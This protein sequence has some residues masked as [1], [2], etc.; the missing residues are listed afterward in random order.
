[1]NFCV[2]EVSQSVEQEN[3]RVGSPESA[4]IHFNTIDVL[5]QWKA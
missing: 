2:G 3:I 4:T 5:L 1:M